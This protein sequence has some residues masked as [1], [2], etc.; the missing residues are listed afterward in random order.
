VS[1]VQGPIAQSVALTI[2]GNDVLH[3]VD[4]S[5]FWPSSTAFKFCKT[6]SFASLSGQSS[7]PDE[8]PFAEHPVGWIS[9]LNSEG[10]VGLRLHHIAG[11]DPTLSD[12]M[13]VGFVGGGGRWLIESMR[14][15]ASDLW[16]AR[17]RVQN[18]NEPD[19]KIWA[20][21]YYRVGVN[22]TPIGSPKRGL[23]ALRAELEAVL[24]KLENFATQQNLAAFA[25]SF[26]KAIDCFG[27][28][29]PL[30]TVHHF[31]IAPSTRISPESKR[32][33]AVAQAAWVFGGMGSWNDLGFEGQADAEYKVLSDTLFS[34][35]MQTICEAAND[36]FADQK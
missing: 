1:N 9:K 13:T 22:R 4:R 10:T 17:W 8:S 28:E 11:N 31:D 21:V 25:G 14:P 18:Q 27:A 36:G 29:S 20:V 16:E 23:A 12:R 33:L 24:S 7:A 35:L 26:R 6:V 5:D 34:L 30:A 19:R 3:G 32:L 15:S 2:F